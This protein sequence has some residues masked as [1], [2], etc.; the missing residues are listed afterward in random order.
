M[1][2]NGYKEFLTFSLK[3]LA[4]IMVP[5]MAVFGGTWSMVRD[6]RATMHTN[7]NR[8]V[9]SETKVEHNEEG[10]SRVQS[11]VDRLDTKLD[12][13]F[14]ALILELQHTRLP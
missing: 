3:V 11:S 5:L 4:I 8:I 6:T 7:T 14:D 1:T 12:T 2:M 13:K 9:A 10:I